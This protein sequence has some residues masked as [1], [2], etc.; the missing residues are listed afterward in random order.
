MKTRDL[1]IVIKKSRTR[2]SASH[3]TENSL[4][5]LI[6]MIIASEKLARFQAIGASN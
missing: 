3:I 5:N 2:A 4:E 6:V 1:E